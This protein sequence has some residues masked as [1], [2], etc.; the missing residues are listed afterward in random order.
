M[1]FLLSTCRLLRS[2][3]LS[4]IGTF[5]VEQL[6]SPSLIT[7]TRRQCQLRSS[8]SST[9]ST[10]G[11]KKQHFDDIYF[12]KTPVPYKTE[13][14][15]KLEYVSD[16]S[17]RQIFDRLI[18][19]WIQD[20]ADAGG[21]SSSQQQSLQTKQLNYVDLCACFGNTTMATNSQCTA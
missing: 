3:P 5:K 10:H 16:T 8:S 4:I 1:T 20:Q 18:L 6:V 11:P 7:V 2:S 19:P 15:D 9:T 12:E 21:G 13:I 17:N 14:L